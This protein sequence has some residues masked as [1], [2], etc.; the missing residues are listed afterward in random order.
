M[1]SWHGLIGLDPLQE[2][3]I[4]LL[5]RFALHIACS[6]V[7]GFPAPI[8]NMRYLQAVYIKQSHHSHEILKSWCPWKKARDLK[9]SAPMKLMAIAHIP[10]ATQ[11]WEVTKSLLSLTVTHISQSGIKDKCPLDR[12]VVHVHLT[13]QGC[14][15]QWWCLLSFIVGRDFSCPRLQVSISFPRLPK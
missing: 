10:P 11:T 14:I 9:L 12:I 3:K 13:S 2:Q 4:S 5:T 15:K 6:S 1:I 7:M 8:H